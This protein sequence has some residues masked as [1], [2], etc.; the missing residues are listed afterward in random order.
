VQGCRNAPVQVCVP[1]QLPRQAGAIP[2]QGSNVEVVELLLVVLVIE[3]EVLVLEV[4]VLEDVDVVD[5]WHVQSSKSAPVQ[6]CPP[7]QLPAQAGATP[8]HAS[9]VDEVVL[10]V[11]AEVLVLEDVDVVDVWHVQSS[12]SAPLQ[13]CP[14]GQLPAQAGATPPQGSRLDEVVLDVDVEVVEVGAVDV[15]VAVDSVVDVDVDVDVE[16]E[17]LVVEIM[18]LSVV[19]VDDVVLVDGGL[20]QD[21]GAEAARATKRP[22]LSRRTAPGP[23]RAH[24]RVPPL[25]RVTSTVPCVSSSRVMPVRRPTTLSARLLMSPT[26]TLPGSISSASRYRYA[27][28]VARTDQYVAGSPK[29]KASV[30]FGLL[31]S[32]VAPTRVG[33]SP[34]PGDGKMMLPRTTNTSRSPD[35]VAFSTSLRPGTS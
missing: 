33:S 15:E 30:V 26:F 23:K 28:P 31:R 18:V 2:P 20:G 13:T 29:L 3:L 7:G 17:V 22:I 27:A 35:V 34:L 9:S 32:K 16:D 11:E 14:S 24:Q 25:V 21:D 1:G 12:K 19:V 4:L 8:P 10:E 5:V 6:T